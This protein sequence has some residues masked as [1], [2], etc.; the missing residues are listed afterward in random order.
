[1]ELLV[2]APLTTQWLRL[3]APPHLTHFWGCLPGGGGQ[4]RWPEAAG[5]AGGTRLHRG[6]LWEPHRGLGAGLASGPLE[7][8]TEPSGGAPEG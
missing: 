8:I 1:M 6:V 7:K 3:S 4:P 5:W 2:G